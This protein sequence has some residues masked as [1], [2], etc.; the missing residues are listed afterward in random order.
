MRTGFASPPFAFQGIK[1]VDGLGQSAHPDVG[2]G[3]SKTFQTERIGEEPF[4]EP[5]SGDACAITERV[6][7]HDELMN[8]HK[9]AIGG[10]FPRRQGGTSPSGEITP[11]GILRGMIRIN[12]DRLRAL[13]VER[14][15]T[16]RAVSRA[17]GNNE[18]L[19]RDIL[20]GKSRNARGDSMAKIAE[21]LGVPVG[22]L[23]SGV[24]G[25]P[26]GETQ[27]I[28]ELPIIGPV[29]AG[30]W[31][32][33]DDYSQVEPSM[34]PAAHDRRYSG[35]KQWLREVK[36][37]SMNARNIYP[38]DLAHLV[39]IIGS[40]VNLNTGMIVE[41]TRTRGGG[42]LKEIT[43]K[44]VEFNGTGEIVLWPRSNNP[45][46]RDPV[47][48]DDGSGSDIEVEITGLLVAKITRF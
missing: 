22:E 7:P 10:N 45:K 20:S 40:G 11:S 17:V 4:G 2:G 39:E 31:L 48:L 5:R 19:V 38:G 18:T 43:L 1:G 35:V 42:T 44:E 47:R 21:H 30:N 13:L 8:G 26:E 32:E 41:V 33:V 16:A 15:T 6:A 14:G 25:P 23:M 24:E 12:R 34:Y 9:S 37:D 3:R 27:A 36:G 46:W 29:Q 28:A